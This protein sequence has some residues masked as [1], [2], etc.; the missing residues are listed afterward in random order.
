MVDMSL[1]EKNMWSHLEAILVTFGSYL[2]LSYLQKVCYVTFG[3]LSD[4]SHLEAI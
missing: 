3:R 4:M 1:M 2:D